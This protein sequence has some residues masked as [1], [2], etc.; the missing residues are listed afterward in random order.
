MGRSLL[1]DITMTWLTH[2]LVFYAGVMCGVALMCW[3]QVNRLQNEI[4]DDNDD[5]Y[6]SAG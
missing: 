3:V 6:P 2:G 4:V 1:L 5:R